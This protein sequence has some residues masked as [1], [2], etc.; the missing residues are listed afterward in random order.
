MGW[1]IFDNFDLTFIYE[2][3]ESNSGGVQDLDFGARLCNNICQIYSILFYVLHP[4][5]D[6]GTVKK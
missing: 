5:N 2:K 4:K 1:Q 6:A 3:Q